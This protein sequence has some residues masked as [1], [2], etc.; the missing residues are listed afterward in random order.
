MA[1]ITIRPRNYVKRSKE[2]PEV[3]GCHVFMREDGSFE[4]SVK[5]ETGLEMLRASLEAL[6]RIDRLREEPRFE[7][8]AEG[9]ADWLAQMKTQVSY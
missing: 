5:G 7:Y 9:M 8:R 1:T 3:W 4:M 6:R 2:T